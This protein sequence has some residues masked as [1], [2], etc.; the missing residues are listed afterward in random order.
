M[1]MTF[2][3]STAR[4]EVCSGTTEDVSLNGA[5]FLAHADIRVGE[6]VSLECQ[7]CSA[8]AIVKSVR[9]GTGNEAGRCQVGVEFLTLRIT[10]ARGGLVSTV[11]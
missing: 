1:P 3:R 11:A 10:H 4:Q 2:R 6:C 7:F 5:R 9:A 8:V